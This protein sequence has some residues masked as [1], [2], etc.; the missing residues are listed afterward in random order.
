MNT[1]ITN[2]SVQ[3]ILKKNP[4]D[5][6]TVTGKKG[7]LIFVN[8]SMIHRGKPLNKKNRYALTNYYYQSYKIEKIKTQFQPML[9][10]KYF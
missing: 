1:R 8:T 9:N 5:L 4:E 2:E 7:T 10:R 3:K 6:I